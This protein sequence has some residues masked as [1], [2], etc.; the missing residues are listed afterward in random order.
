MYLAKEY[1]EILSSLLFVLDDDHHQ[2]FESIAHHMSY[3]THFRQEITNIHK[4]AHSSQLT[5]SLFLDPNDSNIS[6]SELFEV[7]FL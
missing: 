7:D 2:E 1:E 4:M 5:T 6:M 3:S